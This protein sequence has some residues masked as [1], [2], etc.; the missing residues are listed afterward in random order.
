MRIALTAD[1]EIPA[2]PVYYGGIERVIDMVAR[3][4][5][6]RGHE[7]TLFAHPAST[8]PVAKVA[9]PGASSVSRIDTI[10]NASLLARRVARREFDLV[11]SFSRLAYLTPILPFAIPKLMSYQREITPG[12]VGLANRLS[13]GS[14]L[15][16]A[17]SRQMARPVANIGRWRI[18]P[19]GVAI[20]AYAYRA[21]I[22]ADAPLVFLGRV[23]EIKGPHIAIEAARRAG[24]K[25][26]IAGNV[27]D[28]HRQWFNAQ[29]A[30]HL[31]AERV[32]YVGPVDDAQKNDLL[33]RAYALLMPIVWE[34][35]FGI[36]MTEAMAC[37][38]PVIGFRRGAVAEVVESG[39][40]GFVVDTLDEM[41][42]AIARA[43]MLDRSAC[44]A[45]VET[46]YSDNV[47]TD[48]YLK[49]YDEMTSRSRQAPGA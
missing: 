14:L 33:G 40:T 23:E 27:A 45:R 49:L 11:H 39:V 6:A 44:R 3:N 8:C 37:G 2:P 19:N 29:I 28:A 42:D 26:I 15:F 46:H 5:V 25:L 1:P 30:P 4:L 10:R 24:R 22:A 36:V 16:S 20:E 7:V 47:V 17:I 34:E 41:V 43:G 48:G 32:S 31:D 9:W 38:A 12:T 21:A 13:R 35:P 18:V